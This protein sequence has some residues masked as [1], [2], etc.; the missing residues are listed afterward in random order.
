MKHLNPPFNILIILACCVS[1]T[2]SACKTAYSP[3]TL[4][5][6]YSVFPIDRYTYR[7]TVNANRFTKINEAEGMALL[8]ASELTLKSGFRHFIVSKNTIRNKAISTSTPAYLAPLLAATPG[9]SRP[10]GDITIKVLRPTDPEF[11]RGL[12][13][14]KIYRTLKPHFDTK[15]PK[16]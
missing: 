10:A 11:S 7:I 3:T 8:K 16:F 2:L 15:G 9:S 6:G 5:G 1:L 4:T 12:D 14:A 13:A